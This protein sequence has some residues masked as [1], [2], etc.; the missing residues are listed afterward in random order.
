MERK[1]TIIIFSSILTIAFLLLLT[2]FILDI[3]PFIEGIFS[4]LA[5]I[6]L[7][8]LILIIFIVKSIKRE[9]HEKSIDDVFNNNNDNLIIKDGSS[10]LLKN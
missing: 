7:Y 6:N 9:G 4:I 5:P 1:K 3:F 8:F 10:V 2:S